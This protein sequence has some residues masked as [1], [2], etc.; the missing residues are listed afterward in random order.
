MSILLGKS[1]ILT[2]IMQ[3]ISFFSPL[4]LALYAIIASIVLFYQKKRARLVKLIEKIPGPPSLPIIG[5]T[6]EINVD[7]DGEW[8]DELKNDDDT[9]PCLSR[10]VSSME[11]ESDPK[12]VCLP[13]LSFA[14]LELGGQISVSSRKFN[15]V[16]LKMSRNCPIRTQSDCEK[17]LQ[18][19]GKH[20]ISEIWTHL[21]CSCC[22]T[23]GEQIFRGIEWRRRG[24][25]QLNS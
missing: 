1:V 16:C 14:N 15:W 20:R 13:H 11:N 25:F 21:E 23:G 10:L 2:R 4:T 3:G 7:H 17:G 8:T 24:W 9:V 18:L 6:I 19:I 12:M 22:Y 5:N